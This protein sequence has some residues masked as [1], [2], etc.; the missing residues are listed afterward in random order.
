MEFVILGAGALGSVI[1]GHLARTGEDV[2]LISRG[3]R[4][5]YLR[6]QGI[7]VTGLA[8]FTVECRVIT[9]P[10]D[11]QQA[12]VLIVAVKTYDTASALESVRHLEV[13]V[14]LSLQN[15]VLKDDQLAE[16]F[17]YQNTLGAAA[18]TSAE[19]TAEGPVQFTFSQGFHVGELP[20]GSSERVQRLAEVLLAAGI[21]AEVSP[22]IRTTEWSKF[23]AWVGCIASSVLTRLATH[24]FL[25]DSDGAIVCSRLIRETGSLAVKQ[26]IS[27]EDK[28]PFLVKTICSVS[29]EESVEKTREM[30]AIFKAQAPTHRMSTLQDLE[31]GRRLE[32]EETLGYVV[33]RAR[34]EG[35]AVPT[36]ETCYRLIN[37]INGSL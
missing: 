36:V 22:H 28:P 19:L 2:S 10:R 1:A 23:A 6:E 4:A 15:G 16:T 9:D 17:G 3:A 21:Q 14:V 24:K 5:R 7:T 13:P 29:E 26:G 25:S 18:F 11:I 37:G 20:E 34:E 33:T 35:I 8:E 32:V 27:L 30:G 12:D 31:R